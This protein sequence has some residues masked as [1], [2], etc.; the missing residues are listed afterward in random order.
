MQAG[1]AIVTVQRQLGSS[2]IVKVIYNTTDGTARSGTDYVPTTGQLLWAEGDRSDRNISIPLNRNSGARAFQVPPTAPVS[3]TP[4]FFVSLALVSGS[5]G[6]LGSPRSTVLF[7]TNQPPQT[8]PETLVSSTADAQ[9]TAVSSSTAGVDPNAGTDPPQL[10]STG[11]VAPPTNP[12]PVKPVITQPV[13]PD[14]PTLSST[15]VNRP[16]GQTESAAS[17]TLSFAPIQSLLLA[18]F[19]SAILIL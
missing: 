7:I 15:G 3:L 13:P 4:N 2:G 12:E 11:S 17:Q 1:T 16:P 19:I 6:F 5:A 9:P 14:I 8:P 10:S 18:L